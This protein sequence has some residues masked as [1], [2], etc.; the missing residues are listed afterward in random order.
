MEIFT[1]KFS[2]SYIKTLSTFSG[3]TEQRKQFSP[4]AW[5]LNLNYF[6]LITPFYTNFNPGTGSHTFHLNIFQRALCFIFQVFILQFKVY[7]FVNNLSIIAKRNGQYLGSFFDIV[8]DIAGNSLVLLL[9]KMAWFENKTKLEAMLNS[10]ITCNLK[11]K[12]YRMFQITCILLYIIIAYSNQKG[13]SHM[14]AKIRDDELFFDV[15]LYHHYSK[16]MINLSLFSKALWSIQQTHIFLIF[17]FSHCYIFAV[18]FSIYGVSIDFK[19]SLVSNKASDGLVLYKTLHCKIDCVNYITQ[20]QLLAFSV[21]FICYLCELPDYNFALESA[22][23]LIMFALTNA[24]T[25]ILAAEFHYSVKQTVTNWF[26]VICLNG[27]QL[28]GINKDNRFNQIDLVMV[29]NELII[30]AVSLSCRC[31]KVTYGFLCSVC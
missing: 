25:W 27:Y 21:L 1:I 4:L 12:F 22:E 18:A 17:F 24:L 13:V 30:D 31:F 2:N 19:Y 3:T 11:L 8:S 9:L 10:T 16:F 14:L 29:Q 20:N 15:S 7:H 23:S 6:F 5:F 28:K 26:K